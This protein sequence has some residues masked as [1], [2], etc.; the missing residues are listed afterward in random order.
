MVSPELP[1]QVLA[2]H[3]LLI[4]H[5]LLH[6]V[7]LL[8]GRAYSSKYAAKMKKKMLK[9]TKELND[10]IEQ[11]IN[12]DVQE[13]MDM[14]EVLKQEVQDIDVKRDMAAARKYFTKMQLEG[15]KPT[16]FFCNLNKKRLAKAQF[17]ELHVVEKNKEGKEEV[18]V[19]TEQ[20]EIEWEVRKFYWNLYGEHETRVYKKEIVQSIDSPSEMDPE[21]SRKLEC[22][23]TEEE[24]SLT[25]KNTKNNIAPG[26]RG[27]GGH[28]IRFFG[29]TLKKSL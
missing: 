28:F 18:R 9:R 4:S 23:I 2:S 6:D 11:K 25:L 1:D 13:D 19:V 20:R 5:T 15:E 7:I 27:L 29:F 22:G 14:V 10:L 3:T 21:D 12:S 8:E 24:V 17:K 26:P 16:K